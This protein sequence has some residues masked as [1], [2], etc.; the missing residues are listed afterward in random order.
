MSSN[1]F[2]FLERPSIVEIAR[3]IAAGDGR[4]AVGGRWAAER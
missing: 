2:L 3:S 4:A 1:D